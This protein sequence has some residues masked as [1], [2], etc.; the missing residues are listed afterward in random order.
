MRSKTAYESLRTARKGA[1][2]NSVNV[3]VKRREL[4]EALDLMQKVV[5]AEESGKT[6]L[7]FLAKDEILTL[8]NL[9]TNKCKELDKEIMLINVIHDRDKELTKDVAENKEK[10]LAT[11][12]SLQGI[13]D[14]LIPLLWDRR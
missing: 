5:I 1:L 10:I 7:V 11:K 13:K 2:P 12:K 6:E 3:K 14:T 8:V 4:D 9:I